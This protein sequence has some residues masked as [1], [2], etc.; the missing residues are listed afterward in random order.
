VIAPTAASYTFLSTNFNCGSLVIDLGDEVAIHF[1]HKDTLAVAV[2]AVI[3]NTSSSNFWST[4]KKATLKII[5][6]GSSGNSTD[7]RPDWR[8]TARLISA[9]DYEKKYPTKARKD[10]EY[11]DY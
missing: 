4:I 10:K 5:L 11:Q 2:P 6:K 8:R 9:L 7:F 3:F 1:I